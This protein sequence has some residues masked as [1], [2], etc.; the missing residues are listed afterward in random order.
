MDILSQL[1]CLA[2]DFALGGTLGTTHPALSPSF[3]H[4]GR[5]AKDLLRGFNGEQAKHS[6]IEAQFNRFQWVHTVDEPLAHPELAVPFGSRFEQIRKGLP[7]DAISPVTYLDSVRAPVFDCLSIWAHEDRWR[8]KGNQLSGFILPFDFAYG[9]DALS[10]ST[11]GG[12]VHVSV[13]T[14]GAH[15]GPL[16]GHSY[17]DAKANMIGYL[18]TDDSELIELVGNGN[19]SIDPGETWGYWGKPG[20]ELI[21][22]KKITYTAPFN[23]NLTELLYKSPPTGVYFDNVP[24]WYLEIKSDRGFSILLDHI[25]TMA[26]PLRLQILAVTGID[27]NTYA[28]SAGDELLQGAQISVRTGDELAHPQIMADPLPGFPGYYSGYGGPTDRPSTQIEFS[29][30]YPVGDEWTKVCYFELMA[31][32]ERTALQGI[33]DADMANPNSQRYRPVQNERWRWAAEG[34]LCMAYSDL[35]RDFSGLYTALGGWFEVDGPLTS[36]DEIV[37]FCPIATDTQSYDPQLYDPANCG[38]LLLRQRTYGLFHTWLMPDHKRLEVL[39]PA[40][41]ILELGEKHLLLK[42][43]DLGYKG[44]RSDEV[45]VYQRASY[46]LDTNGLKIKWGNLSESITGAIQP[47]LMPGEPCN[48]TSVICYNHEEQPGF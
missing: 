10:V 21:R 38:Y 32:A 13:G 37:S 41:E 33:I 4:F 45:S 19:G 17:G 1:G 26:D 14:F 22:N 46:K 8:L 42:W 2:D 43:R 6:N 30:L 7:G 3:L 48:D 40:A 23:G 16:T 31:P 12:T 28:G 15:F 25:G 39:Y 47:V 36:S 11:P 35:P 18:T 20:G 27:T 5:T 24:Q 44:G 34:R 29:L 9:S